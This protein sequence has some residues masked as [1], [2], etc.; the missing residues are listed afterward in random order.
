MIKKLFLL[1]II[2]NIKIFG[3]EFVDILKQET[4]KA[5]WQSF[6]KEFTGGQEIPKC[7][8]NNI[9]GCIDL[10]NM[11]FN[12]NKPSEAAPAFQSACDDGNSNACF[13]AAKSS[14]MSND[15]VSANKYY[16]KS[17]DFSL[18]MGCHNLAD[19]YYQEGLRDQAREIFK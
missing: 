15:K 16:Q 14:E 10:G 17:C 6:Q 11:L 3:N 13:A 5:F 1:S 4:E 2:I 9:Q 18:P 12:Q 8:K 7:S 19:L